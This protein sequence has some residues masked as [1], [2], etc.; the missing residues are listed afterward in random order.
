MLLHGALAV[1]TIVANVSTPGL[2]SLEGVSFSNEPGAL[3]VPLREMA[4]KLGLPV[5]WDA[6][7]RKVGVGDTQWSAEEFE[8]LYDGTKLLDMKQIE[9]LGAQVTFDKAL[10][11]FLVIYQQSELAVLPG[12]K[13]VEVSLA[14]QRLRAY[15]GQRLVMETNISS[16]RAGHRTPR[17]NF[18]AGPVKT[19]MHYSRL[20]DNSP[21]PYSVQINGHVFIHGYRS[22]P[23]YPASHG[24]IRMPLKG[25]N[26]ARWFYEWVDVGT[27]VSVVSEFP[28]VAMA[29]ED[30]K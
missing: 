8:T 29:S 13:R 20:Y 21:M 4:D 2:D 3:Y 22:V 26:A 18:K 7:T 12:T 27:P 16:G 19:R 14:D 10:G 30:S 11:R 6:E 23:K 15:Q 28:S 24:C 9:A 17:G 25:R 5:T 1:V